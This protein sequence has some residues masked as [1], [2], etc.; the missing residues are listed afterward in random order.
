MFSGAAKE[1]GGCFAEPG[2]MQEQTRKLTACIA[3]DANDTGAGRG[4][5]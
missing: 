3:A 5:A 1:R 2:V 4:G